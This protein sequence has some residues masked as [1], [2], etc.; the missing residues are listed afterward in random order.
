MKVLKQTPS[1]ADASSSVFH[2]RAL[3][4]IITCKCESNQSYL[5]LINDGNLE[6]YR[7]VPHD[8]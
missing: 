1:L 5:Q 3:L 7:T 8:S 4:T 2:V 6:V